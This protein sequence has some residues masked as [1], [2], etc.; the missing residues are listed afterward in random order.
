MTK[1]IHHSQR[2]GLPDTILFLSLGFLNIH[3]VMHIIRSKTAFN[4]SLK[5]DLHF[6]F[7]LKED[8]H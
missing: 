7:S 5:E 4:I 6:K 2:K 8:Y 1:K 3:I